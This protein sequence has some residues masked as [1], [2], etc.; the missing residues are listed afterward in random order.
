M[1]KELN[2]NEIEIMMGIT[3]RID[4][5]IRERYQEF[6]GLF[7]HDL[8]HQGNRELFKLDIENKLKCFSSKGGDKHDAFC[9]YFMIIF[10][11][12]KKLFKKEYKNTDFV[13]S[14]APWVE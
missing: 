2:Q 9:N 8:E 1:E 3:K 6:M 12:N 14:I 7:V 4:Q 5:V 13:K 10:G 11:I